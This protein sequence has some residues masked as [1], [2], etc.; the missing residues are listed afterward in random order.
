[1]PKAGW[2]QPDDSKA[3]AATREQEL[4]PGKSDLKTPRD[5]DWHYAAKQQGV[6]FDGNA[7]KVLV[8]G[9]NPAAGQYRNPP[10]H[11]Y[12][13]TD[14]GAGSGEARAEIQ[15]RLAKERSK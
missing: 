9:D 11:R 14:S 1:M 7:V 12:K 2:T 13:L 5:S 6:G 15:N 3:V 8:R 10:E 4:K